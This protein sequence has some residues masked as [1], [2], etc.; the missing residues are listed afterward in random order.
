M[1][2]FW[3]ATHYNQQRALHVLVATLKAEMKNMR[4]TLHLRPWLSPER[5]YKDSI[6]NVL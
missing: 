2:V 4:T 5:T 1:L 6:A 3:S